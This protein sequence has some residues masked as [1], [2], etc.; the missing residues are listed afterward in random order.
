MTQFR[1]ALL[2]LPFLF[3][4]MTLLTL[5]VPFK[6]KTAV[7]GRGAVIYTVPPPRTRAL[8]WSWPLS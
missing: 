6:S 3:C 4:T 1:S 7:Y 8:M 2:P 5:N